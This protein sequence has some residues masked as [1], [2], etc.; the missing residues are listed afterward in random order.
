MQSFADPCCSGSW[1]L[2]TVL[3]SLLLSYQARIRSYGALQNNMDQAHHADHR[4]RRK[5]RPKATTCRLRVTSLAA[6]VGVF[7]FFVYVDICHSFHVPSQTT[8]I[9]RSLA[10]LS[11][12]SAFTSARSGSSALHALHIDLPIVESLD[13]LDS[14]LTHL[15]SL[16][17]V[18]DLPTKMSDLPSLPE[19]PPLPF[20]KLA[21]QLR[22]E[23]DIGAALGED[24]G[25]V[26]ELETSLVLESIGRDLLVFLAASVVVTPLANI[27]G[28]TPILGY[29]VLGAWLGPNGLDFFANSKADVELGDFGIL[30]LLFSEGLEVS[31]S[32]LNKLA[33]FLP[34]AFAQIALCAGVLSWG[35]VNWSN[36]ERFIPLDDGLVNISRPIEALV[37]ALALTL[38]TSAFVFPVL[39]ERGWE[40]EESG[41][42]ATSILLLQDLAVAPLLVLL[43]FVVGQQP[44]DYAAIGFLT[45]KASIGFGSIIYVGSIIL[46]RVFAWVA[47]TRSTET[48]VALCLLVSV[49]MGTIA[50]TLGLTDTAGAFA[51][52]VLL[53]NTNYRAQ[54]QADILPFKGILLGIFFMVAGSSFDVDLCIRELPTVATGVLALIV[55]KAATLFA[56]TRVPRWLE[57]NRLSIPD[58][59]RLSLLLSGGGEFA[60]VVLALAERLEVLPAELGGLLTAIVLITMAVTPLLGELA[61][62]ASKQF[63]DVEEEAKTSD[64]AKFAESKETEISDNAIIICGYGEI[65]RNVVQV[66]GDEFEAIRRVTSPKDCD[67]EGCSIDA[68]PRIVAFDN[69]PGLVDSILIPSESAVVLFGDGSNP[70]VL[71]SSGVKEPMAIFVAY[72]DPGRVS[73]TTA[74]LRASFPNAAIYARAQTRFEA[75]ALKSL[76]ATEVVVE[77][78]ELPR[79]AAALVW[80]KKLWDAPATLAGEDATPLRQAAAAASG[81]SLELIDQLLE[82]YECIDAD[83]SGHV[84]ANELIVFVRKSNSGVASDEEIDTMEKWV[85]EVVTAPVDPVG[86]CRVYCRAPALIK[87]ALNDAC[88]L[89]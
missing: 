72:E 51:A 25:K 33:M 64:T 40:D 27:V 59:V 60:F 52:G 44:P 48:F 81:V 9:S 77:S 79:S 20:D 23:L 62:S 42:A 82:V 55:L 28:V 37:L 80:G 7:V 2:G 5:R 15:A 14:T 47:E 30:F 63:L 67:D 39:N 34:L 17:D 56:A 58:S 89:I 49:G 18:L 73:S 54:I 83:A 78:D 16:P 6:C 61:D 43:P 76:G 84:D 29:L 88:L 21:N 86:F 75:Q 12:M 74:R 8:C 31:K 53:A 57:P 3:A 70:A 38:S 85:K 65:G 22:G 41:Q 68:L 1:W 87:R 71:L 19:L 50:K 35:I 26:P 46:Q 13:S 66:L 69:N 10:Q 24:L 45:A 11:K 4:R 36:L 32:R